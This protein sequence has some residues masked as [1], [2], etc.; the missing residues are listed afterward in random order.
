MQLLTR[1]GKCDALLAGAKTHADLCA[2]LIRKLKPLCCPGLGL[3]TEQ[4]CTCCFPLSSPEN[5]PSSSPGSPAGWVCHSP[6]IHPPDGRRGTPNKPSTHQALHSLQS[7][8][9]SALTS[10]L[11]VLLDSE[12]S[13]SSSS[14]PVEGSSMMDA[15]G[16][17]PEVQVGQHQCEGQSRERSWEGEK[18]G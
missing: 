15:S 17:F 1:L 9:R 8:H 18:W 7:Q 16:L 12:E 3:G 11:T 2:T 6:P 10:C 4:H 5:T 13:G 14:D